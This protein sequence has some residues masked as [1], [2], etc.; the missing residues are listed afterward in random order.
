MIIIPIGS[1]CSSATFKNSIE[2][3]CTYSLPFD[4]M[5]SSPSFVFEMLV[6][7]L[8]KNMNT[9][10]LVKDHFFYCEKR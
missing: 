1:Q 8:E 6:L 10:V 9:E 4:W 3:T 2:K 5:F 7:L